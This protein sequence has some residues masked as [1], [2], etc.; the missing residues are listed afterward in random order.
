MER[1][2]TER[3]LQKREAEL[4]AVA[5]HS[6]RQKQISDHAAAKQRANMAEKVHNIRAFLQKQQEEQ[7][8]QQ[9]VA[10]KVQ[11]S[12]AKARDVLKR[13]LPASP[14]T[15][16][17]SSNGNNQASPVPSVY[18]KLSLHAV[19]ALE[20]S[21]LAH[22]ITV[23]KQAKLAQERAQHP[24]S[25]CDAVRTVHEDMLQTQRIDAVRRELEARE[26]EK[27]AQFESLRGD[28]QRLRLESGLSLDVIE[29]LLSLEPVEYGLEAR[30]LR[31]EAEDAEMRKSKRMHLEQIEALEKQ[32]AQ[33][34]ARKA[35]LEKDKSELA[36]HSKQVT[37]SVKADKKTVASLREKL[38]QLNAT[39]KQEKQEVATLASTA[40]SNDSAVKQAQETNQSL[41]ETQQKMQV[42]LEELKKAVEQ[43][44]TAAAKAKKE[45]QSE[46]ADLKA[47]L[48]G[49]KNK[50]AE[51]GLRAGEAEDAAKIAEDELR[52]AQQA[53]ETA[54]RTNSEKRMAVRNSLVTLLSQRVSHAP[55]VAKRKAVLSD[56]EK[57][58]ATSSSLS[59]EAKDV[60]S[61]W[62]NVHEQVESLISEISDYRTAKTKLKLK[63]GDD[64]AS[65]AVEVDRAK[66]AVEDAELEVLGR[67]LDM[68]RTV[69]RLEIRR[70]FAQEDI[71]ELKP[72]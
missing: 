47:Q 5:S 4:R 21:S 41:K 10:Q 62:A 40:Q 35:A 20:H 38:E 63:K 9:I 50:V 52:R 17:A 56:P 29:S 46:V 53:F 42:E 68:E 72:R 59:A 70:S 13:I 23:E 37:Q 14:S 6:L 1:R 32:K 25:V 18:S 26:R 3:K 55:Y 66:A 64:A 2:A 60:Q 24:A 43:A 19:D 8:D 34:E 49:L 45:R 51:I 58:V 57:F 44:S 28:I 65:V 15:T 36:A 27:Q 11:N 69:K 12:E 31:E 33:L 54:K 30:K 48:M 7:Q 22:A 61:N 71:N 39:L 67:A 16:N